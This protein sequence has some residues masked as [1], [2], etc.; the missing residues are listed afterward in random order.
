MENARDLRIKTICTVFVCVCDYFILSTA[1][2]IVHDSH[3]I[4]VVPQARHIIYIYETH[5]Y[6]LINYKKT[7]F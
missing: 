4:K 2:A 6:I 3:G 5:K 7:R 1:R